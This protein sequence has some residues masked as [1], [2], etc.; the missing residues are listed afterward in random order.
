[1]IKPDRII[2]VNLGEMELQLHAPTDFL[3]R[4]KHL[5]A[6]ALHYFNT[7]ERMV[8]NIW[9]SDAGVPYLQAMG[10]RILDVEPDD[11]YQSEYDQYIEVTSSFLDDSWLGDA[12]DPPT[13]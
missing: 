1:M 10:I 2:Q 5:G 13:E 11:V 12:I 3:V 8:Q 4:F 6:Q 9:I 7:E